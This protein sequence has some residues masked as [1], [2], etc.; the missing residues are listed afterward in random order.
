MR[1][2]PSNASGTRDDRQRTP[3][4]ATQAHFVCALEGGMASDVQSS[5]RQVRRNAAWLPVRAAV[6]SATASAVEC[7]C[8]SSAATRPA[9]LPARSTCGGRCRIPPLGRVQK[10]LGTLSR[11]GPDGGPSRSCT[12]DSV[13]CGSSARA[14]RTRTQT[15]HIARIFHSAFRAAMMVYYLRGCGSRF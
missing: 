9:T 15:S 3:R 11:T 14:T 8:G 5:Q 4:N 2:M 6:S 13:K 7:A 1:R 10:A 12:R